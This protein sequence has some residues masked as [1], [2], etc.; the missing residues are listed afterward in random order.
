MDD[1]K[2]RELDAAIERAVAES[3]AGRGKPA[4]EVFD[5][6][7]LT[8]R[9]QAVENAIATQRLEGLEVDEQTCV[10]L[11]RVAAGEI[12]LVDVIASLRSRVAAGE[13]RRR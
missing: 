3:R 8:Y 10:E 4:D 6:L 2:L 11:A 1:R 7:G 5:R 12:E 9:R 13:F